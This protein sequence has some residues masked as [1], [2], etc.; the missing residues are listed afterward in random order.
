MTTGP[1]TAELAFSHR[2]HVTAVMEKPSIEM[3]HAQDMKS[4]DLD[5]QSSEVVTHTH[6][7]RERERER[8]RANLPTRN[9]SWLPEA[10]K[11][12]R[13]IFSLLRPV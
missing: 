4:T 2:S 11:D 10:P 9:V 13:H 6:T 3:E 12:S 5:L 1:Q 8:E 7:E